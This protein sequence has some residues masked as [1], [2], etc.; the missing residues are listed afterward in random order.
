MVTR[1]TF[2]AF[3]AVYTLASRRHGTLYTGVTSHLMRRVGEHRDGRYQG[4]TSR[5]GVKHLVWYERHPDMTSAIRRETAIKKYPREWKINLIERENPYWLDL[6]PLLMRAPY[7]RVP[8]S[9]LAE[10]FKALDGN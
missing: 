5:Y 4:F 2:E 8:G 6:Y 10:T 3:I 7:I 9:P 1:N